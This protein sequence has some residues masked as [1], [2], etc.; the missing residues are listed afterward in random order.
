MYLGL[1]GLSQVFCDYLGAGSTLPKICLDVETD[2]PHPPRG[3]E[4]V[5]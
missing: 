5:H 4:K 3:Y 2:D 1:A